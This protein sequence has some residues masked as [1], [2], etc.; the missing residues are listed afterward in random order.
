MLDGKNYLEH[1]VVWRIVNGAWPAGEL[2][3]INGVRDDNRLEN[4]RDSTRQQNMFNRKAT[5]GSTSKYKGVSW[6]SKNSKWVAQCC[7][8]GKV[9]YLGLY[10]TEQEAAK[11]Y[12]NYVKDYHGDYRYKN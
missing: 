1:R 3:H 5:K 4:L 8:S 6:K 10:K 7:I 11:A 12:E 2:D 9:K